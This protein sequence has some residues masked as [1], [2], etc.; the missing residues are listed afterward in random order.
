MAPQVADHRPHILVMNEV[1]EILDLTPDLLEDA[2]Y[3]VSTSLYVL[4]LDR[5][6]PWCPT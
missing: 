2:G 5:I 3:R 4:D 6:R 1:Q